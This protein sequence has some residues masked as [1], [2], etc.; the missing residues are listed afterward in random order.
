M[1]NRDWKKGGRGRRGGEER[2]KR[3]QG[4]GRKDRIEVKDKGRI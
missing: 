1:A 2:M 3:R 4:K